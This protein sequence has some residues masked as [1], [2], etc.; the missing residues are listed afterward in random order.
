[1]KSKLCR[2]FVPWVALFFCAGQAFAERRVNPEARKHLEADYLSPGPGRV[3]VQV[4]SGWGTLDVGVNLH[5]RTW[6]D[7]VTGAPRKHVFNARRL[8]RT[9]CTLY[10]PPGAFP[11]VTE[12]SGTSKYLS[13][14]VIPAE[15]LEVDVKPG[16]NWATLG[17]A[18][19]GAVALVSTLYGAFGLYSNWK[20]DQ[21]G[22]TAKRLNALPFLGVAAGGWAAF[23]GFSY[24]ATPAHSTRPGTSGG[25]GTA[26]AVGLRVGGSF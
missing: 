10:V 17:A 9:P 3:P 20:K 26:P 13:D 24:F 5:T 22:S 25:A 2:V 16:Y 14:L 11:L 21:E 7:A 18:V 23:A 15:G 12:G 8:C 6:V 1:M 4:T 19:T